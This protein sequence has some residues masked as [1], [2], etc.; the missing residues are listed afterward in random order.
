MT[1]DDQTPSTSPLV[2]QA[3]PDELIYEVLDGQPIYYQDF[4]T[5]LSGEKEINEIMGSSIL[6]VAIV[7]VIL[8][9]LY[10]ELSEDAY[11]IGTNEV[12]LHLSK[13]LNPSCDIV[14]FDRA[15]IKD[16]SFDEHYTQ[17][18][19]RIVIEVDTKADVKNFATPLD[20]Y[21]T[22]T[23]RLL[24]FGIQKVIWY[25]SKNQ[26]VTIATPEEWRVLDWT[27]EVEV[28]KNCTLSLGELLA[29]QGIDLPEKKS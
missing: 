15:Q 18:P 22:K 27:K 14:I 11:F 9:H 24:D 6:Q 29:K 17:I 8:R 16:I 4:E 13:N 23:Q 3:I 5:V 19:P 26:K 25:I 10:R 12:G 1:D 2:E 28:L 21:F 7:S 20:Y